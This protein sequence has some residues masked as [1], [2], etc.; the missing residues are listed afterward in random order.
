M[1]ALRFRR[2]WL[3]LAVVLGVGT[4]GTAV[5]H[6]QT[7]KLDGTWTAVAAE[8]DGKP[9][10][11]LK[12]H[13]LTFRGETFAILRDTRTLYKGTYK[14]DHAKKPAQIDFRNLEGDAKG[15][16]WRGI[17]LL[18]GDTLKIVDNAPDVTKPRPT[19]FATK[20]DSGHVLVTFKRAAS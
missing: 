14:A 11:E 3:V 18:D 4:A 8:R 17:Y 9:A 13:R 2:W 6:A 1:G 7:G 15:Q 10:D 5:P 16:M 19:Q 20:P 12:G